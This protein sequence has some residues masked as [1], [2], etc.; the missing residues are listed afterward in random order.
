MVEE[1]KPYF[2]IGHCSALALLLFKYD[3]E[4]STLLIFFVSSLTQNDSDKTLKIL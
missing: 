1:P 3:S 2:N 4:F